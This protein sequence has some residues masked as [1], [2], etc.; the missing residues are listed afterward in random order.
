M[1]D[2]TPRPA[3]SILLLREAGEGAGLEVFMLLRNSHLAFCGGALVFPGGKVESSDGHRRLREHC[4]AAE[5]LED[6]ELR[7]RVAGL[8]ELFEESGIL[9]ARR[10]GA[11]GLLEETELAGL[12]ERWQGA[13]QDNAER[14]LDLLREEGLQLAVDLLEP[15]AHW[16]TPSFL[17]RRFD[18][19]FFIAAAPTGQAARHD[20][21]EAVDSLWINPA[22]ALAEGEAGRHSLVFVTAQN[23][24]LFH[25]IEQVEQALA[26]ARQRPRRSVEPWLEDIGGIRHLRIPDD[27]G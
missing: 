18:T 10:A 6:E 27:A 11:D 19:R 9:L 8:R 4:L 26:M 3:T 2:P 16:V 15:F 5:H 14:F 1:T 20:G 24:R 22:H 21:G 7:F 13:V 23:L 17:E 25:G 12:R